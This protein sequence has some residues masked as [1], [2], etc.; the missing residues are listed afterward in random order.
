MVLEKEI[1]WLKDN[2]KHIIELKQSSE[3]EN[4]ILLKLKLTVFFST[5]TDVVN[6]DGQKELSFKLILNDDG[7]VKDAF[8]IIDNCEEYLIH[9]YIESEIPTETECLWE[10]KF[11]NSMGLI[12]FIIDLMNTLVI[13]FEFYKDDDVTNRNI[14]EAIEKFVDKNKKIKLPLEKNILLENRFIKSKERI[15]EES[16][17]KIT[18]VIEKNNTPKTTKLVKEES[19]PKVAE[20]I[21]KD[22][23]SQTPK[24][25]E[26]ENIPIKPKK[27][28]R[29]FKIESITKKYSPE[30]LSFENFMEEYAIEEYNNRRDSNYNYTL[31]TTQQ[32]W[33]E[34]SKHIGWGNDY[35]RFNR[36]EQGGLLIGRVYKD[37]D[38]IFGVVTQTISGD[39][40]QGSS[41][42]LDMGHD[43]WKN[44][45]DKKDE[46]LKEDD[47]LNVIGW[48]HTHPNNLSVFMSG[49]DMN[50]QNTMFPEHWHFAMVLNPHQKVWKVFQGDDCKIINAY[51]IKKK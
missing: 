51:R 3:D 30:T 19:I 32:A 9:P 8:Y 22:N 38:K 39:L 4:L 45:L 48:Y 36:V 35:V 28:K 34:I 31:Y 33:S 50:T 24:R 43:V 21:E 18:E 49:T 17:S 27:K 37:E 41:S 23:I 14:D 12:E 26:E 6:L 47:G 7:C 42:Y 1:E 2:S 11:H 16:I 25:I 29:R 20:M 10:R 44:M 13:N 15:E 46:L 5:K 40:A